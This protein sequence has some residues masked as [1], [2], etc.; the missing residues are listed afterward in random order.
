MHSEFAGSANSELLA[1]EMSARLSAQKGS[2]FVPE[3]KKSRDSA[4]VEDSEEPVEIY[5]DLLAHRGLSVAQYLVQ[6]E[7]DWLAA[8][9]LEAVCVVQLAAPLRP[10]YSEPAYRQRLMSECNFP[11]DQNCELDH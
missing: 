2:L 1:L 8:E 9:T 7:L 3:L 4:A 10:E 6:S 11:E 5:S